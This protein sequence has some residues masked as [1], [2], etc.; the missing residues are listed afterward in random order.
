MMKRFKYPLEGFRRLLNKDIH[1][2]LHVITSI[3]VLIISVIFKLNSVEWLLIIS[4]IF[5]VL[6]TEALNTAIEEVVDLTTNEYHLHAKYAKDVASFAVLL[7]SLY[8][9]I[10][11]VI[12]FL[13]KILKLLGVF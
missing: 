9:M 2:L 4:A 10:I 13:P 7:S 8:A 3:I 1:F 5:L 6:I 12:I 11:G